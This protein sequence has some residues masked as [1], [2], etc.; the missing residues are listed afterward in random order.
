MLDTTTP[1]PVVDASC[2]LDIYSSIVDAISKVASGKATG[3]DLIPVELLKVCLLLAR[4]FFKVGDCRA[5]FAWRWGENVPVPEKFDKPLTPDTARGVLLGN[6]IAKLWAKMIRTELSPHFALQSSAQ[7]G[8][9]SGGGTHFATQEVKLHMHNATILKKRQPSIAQFWSTFQVAFWT[10]RQLRNS[11]VSLP[12]LHSWH[13][14]SEHQLRK[15]LNICF[16]LVFHPFGLEQQL[17]GT[18]VQHSMSQVLRTWSSRMLAQSL[19][20]LWLI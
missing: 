5:P 8:P 12:F 4:R 10:Q 16:P 3:P 9:S 13:C 20:I 11:L 14:S 15:A 2:L 7:F 19:A 1:P 6:A 18:G 17:I